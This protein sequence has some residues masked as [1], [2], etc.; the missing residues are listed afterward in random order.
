MYYNCIIF[1]IILLCIEEKEVSDMLSGVNRRR[2]F[3][4]YRYCQLCFIITDIFYF[5]SFQ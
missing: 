1:F 5:F 2:N 4:L 3:N